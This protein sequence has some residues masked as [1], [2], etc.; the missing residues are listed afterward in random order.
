MR[1]AGEQGD[2]NDDDT[3]RD[4]CAERDRASVRMAPLRATWREMSTTPRFATISARR[5]SFC[6]QTRARAERD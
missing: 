1:S 3:D 5:E 6:N 4:E 2:E